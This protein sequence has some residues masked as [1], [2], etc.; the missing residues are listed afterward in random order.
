M[1]ALVRTVLSASGGT[2]VM[3]LLVSWSRDSAGVMYGARGPSDGAAGYHRETISSRAFISAAQGSGRETSVSH[4]AVVPT[5]DGPVGSGRSGVG[6]PPDP[7]PPGRDRHRPHEHGEQQAGEREHHDSRRNALELG[8][9]AGGIDHEHGC[10]QRRDPPVHG[11][12]YVRDDY[13]DRDRQDADVR[14]ADGRSCHRHGGSHDENDLK[15]PEDSGKS[16]DHE[17]GLPPPRDRQA[18]PGADGEG[19]RASRQ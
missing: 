1:T 5:G 11:V 6:C 8:G 16:R 9:D 14:E 17:A 19:K 7:P 4:K 10:Y 2:P 13:S 15:R 12:A 3:P 18:S